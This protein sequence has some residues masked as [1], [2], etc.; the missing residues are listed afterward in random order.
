MSFRIPQHTRFNLISS[1]SEFVSYAETSHPEQRYLVHD[2]IHKVIP[3]ETVQHS[4]EIEGKL[5]I[6]DGYEPNYAYPLLIWLNT[7]ADIADIM[8]GLST[9][10]YLALAYNWTDLANQHI[11]TNLSAQGYL[12][13]D[14][15][16]ARSIRTVRQQLNIH[17]ERIYLAG[18]DES[19]T[20]A[21]DLLLHQ[22]EWFAGAICLQGGFPREPHALAAFPK[23]AGKQVFQQIAASDLDNATVRANMLAKTLFAAGMDVHTCI[24]E[25]HTIL[26]DSILREIDSWLMNN[27]ATT[28]HV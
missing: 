6:P 12:C 28:Q 14:H 8:N 13:E 19:A 7:H 21:L 27:I 26:G 18:H 16:L 3:L 10:N 11:S 15:P 23:M 22:P 1:S 25:D 20:L 2:D 9:R 17:S 24:D 5:Y 4:D